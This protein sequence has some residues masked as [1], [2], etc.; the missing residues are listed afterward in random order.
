ML[1]YADTDIC[2]P[3]IVEQS[4]QVVGRTRLA[5]PFIQK[6]V[7]DDTI[8]V[9]RNSLLPAGEDTCNTAPYPN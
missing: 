6:F 7:F 1:G 5:T 3:A 9:P 8:S 4:S 2:V